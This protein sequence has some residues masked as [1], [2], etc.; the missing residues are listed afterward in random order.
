MKFFKASLVAIMILTGALLG[1][2]EQPGSPGS[3]GAA[4]DTD[5]QKQP[6]AYFGDEGKK[7]T[8][9]Q[10]SG[11][12]VNQQPGQQPQGGMDQRPQ[13]GMNPQAPQQE[14]EQK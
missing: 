14:Q 13:G 4:E 5:N 2:S 12:A 7:D 6:R 9:R 1:C 11:G 8:G 10:E 3:Q